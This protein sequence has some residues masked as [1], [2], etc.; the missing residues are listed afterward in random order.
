MEPRRSSSARI[1]ADAMAASV[2]KGIRWMKP[3][4][5]SSSRRRCSGSRARTAPYS[6]SYTTTAGKASSLLE[7]FR[8]AVAIAALPF[9]QWITT[10]VSR[11]IN[12]QPNRSSQ[13]LSR[14]VLAITLPQFFRLGKIRKGSAERQNLGWPR[15]LK[16]FADPICHPLADT[17]VR[18]FGCFP[19]P[20]FHFIGKIYSQVCHELL[21]Y[22]IR[23][24]T[25]HGKAP[26]RA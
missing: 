16:G 18:L 19:Y 6:S 1:A 7:V 14:H 17:H 13:A 3:S 4:P 5:R 9:N 10:L 26:Q 23:Y 2:S 12:D 24:T 11:R 25:R 20:P 8:I 15:C 22:V 21:V